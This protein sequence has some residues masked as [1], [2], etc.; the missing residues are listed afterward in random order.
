MLL[1]LLLLLV[2]L[3]S[4]S[5]W[6]RSSSSSVRS[7]SSGRPPT[8]LNAAFLSDVFQSGDEDDVMFL[9]RQVPGDGGCLF[10]ALTACLDHKYTRAHNDFDALRRRMSNKL[11]LVAV[12]LLKRDND[13][14]IMDN[15]ETISSAQLLAVV[16]E[17]YNLTTVEYCE[18]MCKPNTWGGGPEIVAL[19]NRMRRPIH[20]YELSG[21][22][23]SQSH[24][25][26]T[27]LGAHK[28]RV[29][30]KFGSPAFDSKAPLHILCADGRFPDVG[31]RQAKKIGDHFL[32][33]FPCSRDGVVSVELLRDCLED[34][35]E[36]EW[37]RGLGGLVES[38]DAS[39]EKRANNVP[40]FL[41]GGGWGRG[42]KK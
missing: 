13:T 12:E 8:E 38:Q 14:L 20:V 40:F 30:A 39:Q 22:E 19:S 3:E 16:A 15:R 7:F 9:V 17:H 26:G 27:K 36:R 42:N 31:S 18:K 1:H 11:R 24:R 35:E 6:A 2:L 41:F 32:A 28:L 33:L 37:W 25:H 21:E 23:W 4:G 34:E 10:H 29:C 5:S